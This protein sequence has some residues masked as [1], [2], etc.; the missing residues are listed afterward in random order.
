VLYLTKTFLEN[1]K[2]IA[3]R[4]KERLFL[5]VKSLKIGRRMNVIREVETK[6]V[7]LAQ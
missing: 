2:D 1:Q 7:N 4:K 6:L 3:A 5:K